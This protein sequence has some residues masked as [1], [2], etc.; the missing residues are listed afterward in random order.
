MNNKFSLEALRLHDLVNGVGDFT[1]TPEASELDE[2]EGLYHL[3]YWASGNAR[4]YGEYLLTVPLVG[5][6]FRF[7]CAYGWKGT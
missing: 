4:R 5:D 3:A 6:Y 2:L 7:L 1:R